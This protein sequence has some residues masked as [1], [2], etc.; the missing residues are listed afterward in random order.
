MMTLYESSQNDDLEN[1]ILILA[2]IEDKIEVVRVLL[3][4]GVDKLARNKVR[5]PEDCYFWLEMSVVN[6]CP[7]ST[8]QRRRAGRGEIYAQFKTHAQSS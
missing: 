1:T 6:S 5:R 2:C 8:Y 4:H 3:D 7:L